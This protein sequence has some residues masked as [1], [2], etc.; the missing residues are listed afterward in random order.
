M[1][2]NYLAIAIRNLLKHKAFSFINIGGLAVGMACCVLLVLYIH[3]EFSYEQH[4]TDHER[5]YRIYSVFSRDGNSESFP[6]TSPPVAMA[7]AQEFPEVETATRLVPI[8]EVEQHL[9]RY[10][11]NLFYEKMGYLADSTFF[12]VFSF[13]FQEGDPLTALDRPNTV[14]VTAEL[15]EKIFGK[16]EAL[17][18]P[19][20]ISSGQFTDTLFISGVLKPNPKPSHVNASF[21][22]SMNGHPMGDYINS[23]TT[24]AW[25]NFINSYVKLKP[26]TSPNTVDEK[27][28]ALI[29]KHSGADLK[30]A[31]LHK[32]MHLQ[33]LDKIHL[34]SDFQNSFGMAEADN[35]E[36]I[37]ILGSIGVFILLLACI[38]FMNLTTAKASQRAGEVGVR[39]SLGATRQNLIRQFLGESMTI[40]L[41]ALLLALIIV[42]IAL[43]FFNDLTQKAL[44]LQS[45][46][47]SFVLGIMVL[48]GIVT[49]LVAGSYPAFFLSSF[50]PAIVL[51]DKRLSGGSSNFLRKGLVV[52][53][54]VI[55]ITLISSIV[56]IQRQLNFIQSKPLGFDPEYKIMIPLRTDEAKQQYLQLKNSFAQIGGVEKISAARS[57]PSTPML[58]DFAVY[59]KGS[60][61]DRGIMHRNTVV[62]ENYFDLLDIKLL[63]G[64]TPVYETDSFSWENPNRKIMVNKASLQTLNIPL[65]EALGTQLLS[66]WQGQTFTHEIIGV[67][68]DFH[69]FSLHESIAPLIFWIPASRENYNFIIASVSPQSY[70]HIIQQMEVKWKELVQRTPFE[71]DFLSDSVKRQYQND[72]RVSKIIFVFTTLAIIISCLGLYGLSVY[73]AERKVKEIGIR[74][75]LGGSVSSIVGM[76]SKEF[77]ILIIIAL[78]IAAPV[79][80]YAMNKWLQSFAYKIELNVVVFIITG[81][82]S[83]AIAWLT[84][85]FESIKAAMANPVKSLRNE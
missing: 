5:I 28:P 32:E 54:F 57:L 1:F 31:G 72:Q 85:G 62:D 37:Y 58:S 70:Q 56:I 53:Q 74:K 33:P 63:A 55:S 39:K 35:I 40:V 83:L 2:R 36:Y 13:E 30:N 18:K 27:I 65:E 9:I 67:V 44:S 78:V 25:Q 14:V 43:P 66:E 19:I 48:I 84:V 73:V 50:Q 45:I 38:N 52:F 79:G 15:A 77:V 47:L 24:W 41:L 8:P 81:I 49:A 29:E 22:M 46:N 69:Q 11:E 82:I 51:K 26:N 71:A 80:Y 10:E 61:Q 60:S 4:F 7:L 6:R 17:D 64:R 59:P 20:I 12:D 23:V 68:D 75:V 16:T 21:Y 3:D 76:L 34:H 42:Q